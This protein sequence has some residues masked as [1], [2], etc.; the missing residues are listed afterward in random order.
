MPVL[1][2]EDRR[3]QLQRHEDAAC[4]CGGA[5]EDRPASYLRRVRA[6]SAAS[7]GR[8]QEGAQYRVA[9]VRG[10]VLGEEEITMEVILREDIEKLGSR[11]DRKSTRLNSSHTPLSR[12]PS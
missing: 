10:V 11:G 6:T 8:D 2:R 1:R 5:R 7:D 12:M 9:S 3:H 4:V